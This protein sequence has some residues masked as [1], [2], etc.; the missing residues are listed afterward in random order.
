MSLREDLVWAGNEMLRRG[1]TVHTAGNLSVRTEDN[2]GFYVTPS[3]LPYPGIQPED[4]VTIDW[5]GHISAGHRTPSIEHDLH[6]FIYLARLDISAIVHSHSTYATT[7][8]ASRIRCGI[9]PILGEVWGYLKG[10]VLLAEYA[11]AGSPELAHSVVRCLGQD[12]RG[13]LLKNH[14][15]IALGNDL[16]QAL[17]LAEVIEK[18]A[19]SFVLAQILG[20][21]D[22]EPESYRLP[23]S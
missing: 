13:A 11:P 3:S 9:P 15:A 1:L 16:Q 14:G 8:A 12:R 23:Q 5:E 20:G 18:A 22:L 21:Y 7:L 17:S 10:P 6:R 4:L 2:S 19:E